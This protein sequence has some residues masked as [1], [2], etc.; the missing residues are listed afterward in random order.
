MS[1]GYKVEEAADGAETLRMMQ[2]TH[3]NLVLL[4]MRTPVIDGWTLV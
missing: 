1:E 4:D 2:R 3:S